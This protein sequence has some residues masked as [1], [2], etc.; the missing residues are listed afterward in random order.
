MTYGYT[1]GYGY[2]KGYGYLIG[3]YYGY[4]TTPGHSIYTTTTYYFLF[5]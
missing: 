2:G 4:A 3:Y 1:D 5:Y